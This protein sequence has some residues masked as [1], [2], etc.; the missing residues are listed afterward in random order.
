MGPE[1]GS[2]RRGSRPQRCRPLSIWPRAVTSVTRV[3]TRH[4]QPG[5]RDWCDRCDRWCAP[6]GQT[7]EQNPHIPQNGG[8]CRT[9][10]R[11]PDDGSRSEGHLLCAYSADCARPA[12]EPW[13]AT[14]RQGADDTGPFSLST[15]GLLPYTDPEAIPGW[16]GTIDPPRPGDNGINVPHLTRGLYGSCAAGEQPGSLR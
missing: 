7:P 2:P 8:R 12:L 4:E 15:P 13:R 16:P 6:R 3:T 1:T 14:D 11:G 10:Q 5:R 9:P